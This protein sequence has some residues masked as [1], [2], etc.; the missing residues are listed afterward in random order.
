MGSTNLTRLETVETPAICTR[1]P[2][3]ITFDA[4]SNPNSNLYGGG[5]SGV[6]V[7]SI[8]NGCSATMTATA[9]QPG[10]APLNDN[11]ANATMISGGS[12]SINGT[13]VNA[14]AEASRPVTCARHAPLRTVRTRPSG[15]AGSAPTA[16]TATLDTCS[17]PDFDSM[18][19]IYTGSPLDGLSPALGIATTS[20]G[21]GTDNQQE[22]GLSFAVDLGHHL[23]IQSGRFQGHERHAKGAF[24]LDVEH[25]TANDN[26]GS[27]A[28][29][30]GGSGSVTG[31]NAGAT[32]QTSEPATCAGD[33]GCS[34]RTNGPNQTVW[35]TWAAPTTGT[36]SILPRARTSTRW[37]RSIRVRRLR[38]SH[39]L[40]I[41]TTSPAA[42]AASRAR[43]VSRSPPAR[44]TRSR[45]TVSRTRTARPT[46]RS[47]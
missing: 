4:A 26:F 17:A 31:T 7:S 36:A 3:T 40:S 41:T 27:A 45:S 10:T 38:D 42:E 35:Y 28:S 47:P 21:C 24:T 34:S 6:S 18:V 16:G 20:T 8:S 11:F 30:T 43:R 37:W 32:F 33:T 46:V 14:T 5:P 23:R 22:Q 19:A 44:R 12:G 1:G 13:N 29:I 2:P 39:A 25:A 15:T 9:V